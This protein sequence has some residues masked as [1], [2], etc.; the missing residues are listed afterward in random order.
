M[1]SDFLP[2]LIA[3]F[4]L[5]FANAISHGSYHGVALAVIFAALV[6]L[7]ARFFRRAVPAASPPS[8]T[9]TTW[10][11]GAV[12]V[13]LVSMPI[14]AFFDPKIVAHPVWPWREGR[15]LEWAAVALLATYVP[16]LP[17]TRAEPTWAREGRLVGFT[18]LAALT[19]LAVLRVS[20]SPMIDVWTLQ[21]KGAEA[22]LHGQNPFATVTVEDTDPESSF[23]VP[24]VYP[25]TA[26]YVGALGILVGR[27]VRLTMVAAVVVAGL[28]IQFVARRAPRPLPSLVRDAPMLFFWLTPILPLVLELSWLDPIQVMLISVGVALRVAGRRTASAVALGLALSSKQ[29]MFWLLPL[30][31]FCL[32]YRLREWIAI[33]VA[34]AVPV[35]PF[36]LWDLTRLKFANFDFLNGLPPRNDALCVAVWFKRTF[37]ATFPSSIAFVLSA[38]CVAFAAFRRR[39]ISGFS[40]AAAVTYLCF[41]LFNKW[42]FANYYFLITGLTA[43]AAAASLHAPPASAL[44]VQ[45]SAPRRRASEF[46]L[47]PEESPPT[48]RLSS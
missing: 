23:T 4:L 47:R 48:S 3:A 43:L 15:A 37:H 36:A 18:L 26:L 41:F 1:S 24:Y 21:M 42:A 6:V 25:P 33:V 46:L 5:G 45:P 40:S 19:G 30:A 44:D 16:W 38:A 2:L 11:L 32:R 9:K 29:S 22:L 13:M 27:D 31:G 17:A 8:H 20:P 34:A 7:A 14:T 35:A 28:A 12:L 39:S 10:V